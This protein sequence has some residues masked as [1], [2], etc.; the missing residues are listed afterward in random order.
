[1]AGLVRGLAEA[2]ILATA[3]GPDRLRMVTHYHVDDAAVERVVAAVTR[4]LDR[5]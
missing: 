1:V 4:L 2:G 5:P 3:L